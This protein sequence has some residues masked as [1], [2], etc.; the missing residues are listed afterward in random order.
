MRNVCTNYSV[1]R[2]EK[3]EVIL[4]VS[5]EPVIK[6]SH[7]PSSISVT[8]FTITD[9]ICYSVHHFFVFFVSLFVCGGKGAGM[10]CGVRQRF[11][12]IHVLK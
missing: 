8:L 2:L 9:K 10:D 4:S 7:F 6:Q 3:E 12:K 1:A 11:L 5:T